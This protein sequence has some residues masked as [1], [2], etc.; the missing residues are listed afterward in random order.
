MQPTQAGNF[1]GDSGQS[2]V[3]FRELSLKGG[4]SFILGGYP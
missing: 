3:Y 1:P 4:S 2:S